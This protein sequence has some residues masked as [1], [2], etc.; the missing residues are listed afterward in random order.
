MPERTD[1]KETML[2]ANKLEKII[3]LEDTLRKEYQSKLDAA[4][5]ELEQCKQDMAQQRQELQATIDKQLETIAELSSKSESNQRTEQLNRELTNRADKL[6]AEVTT[7]KQ[8][9]KSLQKDLASE[10]EELKTLKQFDPAR[11]KKNL[12]AGK[13]KLAE[14]TKAADLL[15]RNLNKTKAENSE[16][17]RKV[18][19]LEAKLADGETPV[20]ESSEE[21]A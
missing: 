16:L 17:Q 10:R 5:A 11:M 12:D 9:V 19:E 21:A 1:E 4:A 14:K 15:Q 18:E 3:E 20:E 13:K 8:R 7:L 6:Q 2:T